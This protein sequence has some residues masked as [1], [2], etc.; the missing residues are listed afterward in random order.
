[1]SS[2]RQYGGLNRAPTN[3]IVRNHYSN[4]DNPTIS[5]FLGLYNSKIVSES[6]LDLSGNSILNVHGIYFDNSFTIID[7]SFN[8]DVTINGNLEVTKNTQLDGSLNVFGDAQFDGRVNGI[9]INNGKYDDNINYQ[10][11]ILNSDIIQSSNPL[12]FEGTNNTIVGQQVMLNATYAETNSCFGFQA[13]YNLTTGSNNTLIGSGAGQGIITGSFNT[14]LGLDCYAF[15][16]Y[17]FSTAIG[18]GAQPTGDNQIMLGRPEETVI[19]PGDVSLNSTLSVGGDATFDASMVVYGDVSLNSTLEVGGD[20]QFDGRVNGIY[21]N[22]GKYD[23]NI[24]NIFN[25]IILNSDIIQSTYPLLFEG[26]N[27]TIVG[28]QV[29]LNAT[30]AEENSCFGF[31]T[32]YNLITGRSN[33]LIG[34]GAG[35]GIINGSYNTA[36]G[37]NSCTVGDYNY[38]TG[39]GV[40][41]QPTGDNQIMLGRPEET[42]ICPGSLL[43]SDGSGNSLTFSTPTANNPNGTGGTSSSIV[44][45]TIYTIEKAAPETDTIIIT[46]PIAYGLENFIVPNF[47]IAGN[48]LQILFVSATC[49]VLRNGSP[50]LNPTVTSTNGE[51]LLKQYTIFSNVV[52]FKQFFTNLETEFTISTPGT[53]TVNFT[54]NTSYT[55]NYNGV[56]TYFNTNVQTTTNTLG[57][58]IFLNPSN[59]IPWTNVNYLVSSNYYDT[60][61]ANGSIKTTGTATATS[62]VST[63]DYRIKT[64]IKPL[65]PN[66]AIDQLNPVSYTNKLSG[67]KDTGFIAH[68]IQE[69]FPHLVTG[70]KDG[71]QTQTLNYIGLI[72]IL[73]REIQELKK[74]I[75]ILEKK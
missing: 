56:T 34:S 36:L 73:T 48:S 1:M 29:M 60:I 68:E 53:Y 25:N 37:F 11:I 45:G 63:S 47:S 12:L 62:F 49:S 39:I 3:N 54:V 38:S 14:A 65:D 50:F 20:A 27:N 46:T 55:N 44:T 8:G 57:S 19:C 10:N 15:G 58:V 23:N 33:T 13:G 59:V 4:S 61:I 30:L 31:Q 26:A 64:D 17:N 43:I 16:D 28:Q 52:T 18:V 70:E 2:F 74:R 51:N 7:G 40:G 32:G 6:H 9:Y 67:K 24:F 22:N 41:A 35:Q 75:E 21:I 5:N 71:E 69:I 72:A 42:V 66:F